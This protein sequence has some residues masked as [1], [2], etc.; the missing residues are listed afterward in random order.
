MVPDQS[1]F[2][3]FG[4]VLADL[5]RVQSIPLGRLRLRLRRRILSF[6]I[7]NRVRVVRGSPDSTDVERSPCETGQNGAIILSLRPRTRLITLWP[8]ETGAYAAKAPFHSAENARTIRLAIFPARASAPTGQKNAGGSTGDAGIFVT[9]DSS[10]TL[11]N[12]PPHRLCRALRL[13]S[14]YASKPQFSWGLGQLGETVEMAVPGVGL[15]L[16]V[17]L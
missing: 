12:L 11:P 14:G 13:S 5:P 8:L 2:S 7:R 10:R 9:L 15:V 1:W 6:A 16:S 3:L 17:S 4:A